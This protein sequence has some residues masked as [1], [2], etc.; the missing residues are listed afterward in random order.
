ME[1]VKKY[2][3][4]SVKHRF[5]NRASIVLCYLRSRNLQ[6]VLADYIEFATSIPQ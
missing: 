1:R 4:Y 5:D 6:P 2:N 3:D